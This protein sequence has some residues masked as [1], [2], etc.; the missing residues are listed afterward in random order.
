MDAASH[1]DVA[2]FLAPPPETEGAK[3]MLAEQ[4]ASDGYIANF[5]KV[6]AWRPDVFASYGAMRG[7]LV[8]ASA[9]TERD[10]AV[11][12]DLDSVTAWRLL[13][14][15]RVGHAARAPERRR[16][17]GDAHRGRVGIGALAA[18]GRTGRLGPSSRARS[19]WDD[20]GRRRRAAGC[21]PRRPDHLRS[22]GVHRVEARVLDDQRRA[23]CGAR[24]GARRQ[25][26][27][28]GAGRGH[29][30]T[31]A[32][33]DVPAL[34]ARRT[35]ARASRRVESSVGSAELESSMISGISVQPRTTASHPSF[36]I[37]SITA[38]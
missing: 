29:L 24:S 16:D 2:M 27:C 34:M 14:L 20:A 19:Q 5:M 35:A 10:L 3:A 28:C 23:R 32:L 18:G 15:T 12:V 21:R 4:Q 31:S 38:R 26:A 37:R 9:L 6:W 33:V 30:R 36:R 13:L 8:E 1:P 25:G 17:G 22:D 7:G 11:L